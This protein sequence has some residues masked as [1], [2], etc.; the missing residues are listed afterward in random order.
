MG[1]EI[2][3]DIAREAILSEFENSS[4]N[5]D[6]WVDK[7]PELLNKGAVFVTLT[8]DRDLRGCI[9]SLI[10]YRALIE[11]LVENAKSAAFKDPRFKPLS[12]DE[13]KKVELEVSLLTSPKLLEYID[14]NDLKSKIRPNIDGVILRLG[15]YQATFLPQVWEQ[16]PSFELFFAHLCQKANL[17]QD[18]LEDHPDIFIY[19]VKKITSSK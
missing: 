16:L 7:Y 11:D 3:L 13:F 12:I 17:N 14:K 6:R 2:L 1:H 4:F 19:E 15:S 5:F 9:G 10:A 8:L 18:C